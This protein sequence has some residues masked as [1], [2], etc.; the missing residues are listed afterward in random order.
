MSESRLAAARA[1]SSRRSQEPARRAIAASVCALK[2]PRLALATS[3]MSGADMAA[4]GLRLL[5]HH[6]PVRRIDER[7]EDSSP[8]RVGE[9]R[10]KS[11][12]PILLSGGGVNG[13]EPEL[14]L[15]L[16]RVPGDARGIN[17][18]AGGQKTR[19]VEL[20][21]CQRVPTAI[22]ISGRGPRLTLEGPEHIAVLR[23]ESRQSRGAD[24]DERWLL[25][26]VEKQGTGCPGGLPVYAA[27]GGVQRV[28]SMIARHIQ[29]ISHQQQGRSI[30]ERVIDLCGPARRA[31]LRVVGGDDALA[32]RFDGVQGGA[33]EGWREGVHAQGWRV[34]RRL[35]ERA[36]IAGHDL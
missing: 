26:L 29:R 24:S 28:E 22:A 13:E 34:S 18:A 35:P 21:G 19:L 4:A 30:V 1:S 23:I 20:R 17:S 6:Q 9:A 27:G 12:R 10:T 11:F 16:P 3:M 33:I 5:D 15:R 8:I 32:R 31:V 14:L 36:A 7:R 2:M 25:R